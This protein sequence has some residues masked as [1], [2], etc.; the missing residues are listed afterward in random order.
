MCVCFEKVS[1]SQVLFVDYLEKGIGGLGT[2][3]EVCEVEV[4]DGVDDS[5]VFCLGACDDILPRECVGFVECVDN[6][7]HSRYGRVKGVCKELMMF[8]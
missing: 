2:N 4:E 8:G 5:A 3:C 1:D 7:I 6:W